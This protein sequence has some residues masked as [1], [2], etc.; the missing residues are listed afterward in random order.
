MAAEVSSWLEVHSERWGMSCWNYV[1]HPM[2]V[3]NWQRCIGWWK[4]HSTK[5]IHW[6]FFT[7]SSSC[8]AL[9]L[10]PSAL[11]CHFSHSSLQSSIMFSDNWKEKLKYLSQL[12]S[13]SL[14]AEHD[15]IKMCEHVKAI[16][17]AQKSLPKLFVID[18]NKETKGKILIEKLSSKWLLVNH[19]R[20]LCVWGPQTWEKDDCQTVLR[21][22][23][24]ALRNISGI[25]NHFFLTQKREKGKA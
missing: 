5:V 10:L 19:R 1:Y 17:A 4:Q 2:C 6:M 3:F 24:I 20:A 13:S 15:R 16:S 14:L 9:M 11:C 22:K 18:A 8:P 23:L 12:S 7:I 21:Q 25:Q